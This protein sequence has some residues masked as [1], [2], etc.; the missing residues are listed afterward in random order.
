M[1]KVG[2]VQIIYIAWPGIYVRLWII[3]CHQ[4]LAGT[5]LSTR[6]GRVL[7]HKLL[8]LL[9]LLVARDVVYRPPQHVILHSWFLF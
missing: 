3:L 1:Y 5:P 6:D 4:L 7:L 2:C 9:L 8:L